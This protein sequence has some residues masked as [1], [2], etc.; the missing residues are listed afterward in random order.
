MKGVKQMSKG[1]PPK[2]NPGVSDGYKKAKLKGG[3]SEMGPGGKDELKHKG[4]G[5][6]GVK[7]GGPSIKK[8]AKMGSNLDENMGKGDGSM[9]VK[10]MGKPVKSRMSGKMDCY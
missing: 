6:M 4:N 10:Q 5:S 8:I 2:I 7:V 3:A 1:K 9:G